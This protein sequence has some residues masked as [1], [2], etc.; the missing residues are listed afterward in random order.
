MLHQL[1][2]NNAFLYGILDE[3]VYME[4]PPDFVAQGEFGQA[5]HLMKVF[6]WVEAIS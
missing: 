1:D 4:Q 2:I 5:C 3:E 6:I